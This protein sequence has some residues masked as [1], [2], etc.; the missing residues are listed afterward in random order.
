MSDKIYCFSLYCEG[1]G[2]T[3]S[4]AFVAIR[5]SKQAACD[6]A[7]AYNKRLFPVD[8]GWGNHQMTVID[9]PKETI[10]RLAEEYKNENRS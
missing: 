7:D 5:G 1:H 3:K 6:R 4:Q 9:I 2:Q 10:L 8:K